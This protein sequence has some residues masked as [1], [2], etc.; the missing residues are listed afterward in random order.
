MT[1]FERL[2]KLKLFWFFLLTPIFIDFLI[3][4]ISG[5]LE[6]VSLTRYLNK[7]L[8][9]L[10]VN[11]SYYTTILAI[12]LSYMKY[13]SDEKEHEENRKELQEKLL[14]EEIKSNQLKEIELE[15]YRDQYR[16]T[17]VRKNGNLILLM[18][19][20]NLY[21]R[22]V[23]FFL[24]PSAFGEYL[25]DLKHGES[26][27]LNE[28]RN[29]YYISGETLI[30]EKIVF[31]NIL[32]DVQVYKALKTGC[33]PIEKN[34]EFGIK[35]IDISLNNWISF[36]TVEMNINKSNVNEKMKS[37]L[38][39]I[40]RL[41][42]NRTQCIRE[43]MW[44]NSPYPQLEIMNFETISQIFS[45]TLEYIKNY[46]LSDE[47]KDSLVM[48]LGIIL[49]YYSSRIKITLN[50]IEE[51]DWVNMKRNLKLEDL[52]SM[53]LEISAHDLYLNIKR[54]NKNIDIVI[55]M[56]ITLVKYLKIE[57]SDRDK[58]LEYTD[59]VLMVLNEELNYEK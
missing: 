20:E 4:G 54:N 16:P 29:N 52:P 53:D 51:G 40:D 58:L 31:G 45:K 22:N 13:L 59:F 47:K 30:G 46:S 55:N 34:T 12:G 1:Y 39:K 50:E 9:V 25:G 15:N 32:N 49:Y 7:L 11:I 24:S 27:P 44:L 5:T 57:E 8:L 33:E 23:V 10:K 6:P 41:F 18:R 28:I 26:I 2:K 38:N 42:M 43:L 3:S 21:L 35:E 56:L 48:V 36:N 14:R 17:F 19:K 37:N